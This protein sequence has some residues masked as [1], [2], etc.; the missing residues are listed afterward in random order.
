MK[1][2]MKI[3]VLTMS[4]RP[5]GTNTKKNEKGKKKTIAIGQ[6]LEHKQMIKEGGL[7]VMRMGTKM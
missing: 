3:G 4:H 1:K 7:E 2:E 6:D 5:E